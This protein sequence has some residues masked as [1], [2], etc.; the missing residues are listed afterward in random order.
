MVSLIIASTKQDY[1]MYWCTHKKCEH[2]GKESGH[3]FFKMEMTQCWGMY[4]LI[5]IF[6]IQYDVA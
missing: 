3:R 1:L 2:L 6:L 5:R 4:F